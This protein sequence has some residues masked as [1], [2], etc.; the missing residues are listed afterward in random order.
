M[1]CVWGQQCPTPCVWHQFQV[2]LYDVDCLLCSGFIHLFVYFSKCAKRLTAPSARS[3]VLM[4][5]WLSC[6]RKEVDL[7]RRSARARGQSFSSQNDSKNRQLESDCWRTT[8]KL[9]VPFINSCAHFTYGVF[10]FETF[11]FHS[12]N[13]FSFFPHKF[14][15]S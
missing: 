5:L 12:T 3:L 10:T 6:G 9:T 1:S 2:S 8:N 4:C 14:N 13:T 11:F 7:E 15:S